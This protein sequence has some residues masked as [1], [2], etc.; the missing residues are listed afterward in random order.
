MNID[1]QFFQWGSRV[2]AARA[3]VSVSEL[4]KR[5]GQDAVMNSPESEPFQRELCKIAVAAFETAGEPRS[6]HANLFRNLA[7]TDVWYPAYNKFTDSVCRA[8]SKQAAAFK[9]AVG[10]ATL[11][12]DK[13]GGGMAKTLLAA[14]A[15]TGGSLGALA[16]LLNRNANQS[17]TESQELLEKIRAYK[18]LKRDIEEDVSMQ[19][20]SNPKKPHAYR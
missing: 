3:G 13:L 9:P 19:I 10:A 8:L 20:P 18:S 4:N 12:H 17:S 11:L 7:S 15:L 1:N 6:A 16:F 2:A 5:A 14:S